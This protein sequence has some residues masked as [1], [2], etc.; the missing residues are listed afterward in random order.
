[1]SRPLQAGALGAWALLAAWEHI[2]RWSASAGPG[3]YKTGEQTSH[4]HPTEPK[5]ISNVSEK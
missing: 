1:M 4:C 5:W 2:S 3:S